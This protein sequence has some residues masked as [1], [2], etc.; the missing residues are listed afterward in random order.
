MQLIRNMS[1]SAVVVEGIFRCEYCS[2]EQFDYYTDD[3]GK[4][5]IIEQFRRMKCKSCEKSTNMEDK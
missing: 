2:H 3:R 4:K 5:D 1:A